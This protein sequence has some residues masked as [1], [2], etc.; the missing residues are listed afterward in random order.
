MERSYEFYN[1]RYNW[2]SEKVNNLL[3]ILTNLE[4]DII[5]END[6]RH[7]AE[8]LLE[9]CI[10]EG[11]I[12]LFK[13]LISPFPFK[14][15]EVDINPTTRVKKDK[16]RYH[17]LI[18]FFSIES[19]GF[20]SKFPKSIMEAYAKNQLSAKY[21]FSE[22]KTI[23]EISK[24]IVILSNDARK[25]IMDTAMTLDLKVI[26]GMRVKDVLAR[27]ISGMG[28]PL[29]SKEDVK[30]YSETPTVIPSMIL[31]DYN[32]QT[33]SNDTGGCYDD[34]SNDNEL[35]NV[36]IEIDYDSLSEENKFIFKLMCLKGQARV[37]ENP[38]GDKFYLLSCKTTPNQEVSFVSNELVQTVEHFI[39]Q[40]Y[41]YGMIDRNVLIEKMRPV[42]AD[43][44]DEYN[45]FVMSATNSE[46]VSYYNEIFNCSLICD[47]YGI[48]KDVSAKERHHE[49][50]KIKNL[51]K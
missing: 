29:K 22:E 7:N 4:N 40:D 46:L 21:G 39:P 16:I 30:F 15:G 8:D 43:Q 12:D 13:K 23:E 31:Y 50:L 37:G 45:D 34:N 42:Y 2:N 24:D 47:E 48:Y 36:D 33:L 32:I 18:D 51:S 28:H 20:F 1:K 14:T 38:R 6:I 17:Y 49:F 19:C 10:C 26:K 44:P 27:K 9:L 11:R 35:V 41:L 25:D 3:S 5:L